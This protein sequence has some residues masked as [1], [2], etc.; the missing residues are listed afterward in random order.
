M[1]EYTFSNG[2]TFFV[3]VG[4]RYLTFGW[5]WDDCRKGYEFSIDT[6]W[7]N[8]LYPEFILFHGKCS[9]VDS[10][11]VGPFVIRHVNHP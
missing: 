4:L 5:C 8:W 7:K 10:L 9:H 1:K 3:A 6:V 2:L 11:T